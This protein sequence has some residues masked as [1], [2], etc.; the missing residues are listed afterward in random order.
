MRLLNGDDLEVV[1]SISWNRRPQLVVYTSAQRYATQEVTRD[2]LAS[3]YWTWSS[4]CNVVKF[5]PRTVDANKKRGARPDETRWVSL[6][7]ISNLC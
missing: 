1:S 2:S 4:A 6:A 5:E 7:R 3:L